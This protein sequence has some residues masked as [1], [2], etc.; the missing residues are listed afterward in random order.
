[1]DRLNGVDEF[2]NAISREL[3]AAFVEVD[4]PDNV[5]GIWWMDVSW[6]DT[7]AIVEWRP[8]LGYGVSFDPIGYGE[9]AENIYDNAE[10]AARAV[11]NSL[12]ARQPIDR[13]LLLR[14]RHEI[15]T[16]NRMSLGYTVDCEYGRGNRTTIRVFVAC[17]G[18]ADPASVRGC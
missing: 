9:G 7:S 4:R 8:K 6:N 16:A 3:P 5:N 18:R 11:A 10:A 14:S 17:A 15:S 12:R 1:M 13:V 2:R